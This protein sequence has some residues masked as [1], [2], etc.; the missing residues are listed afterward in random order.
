MNT[1]INLQLLTVNL[2]KYEPTFVVVTI[3]GL[4]FVLKSYT[5]YNIDFIYRKKGK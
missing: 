3:R 1:L 2:I 4:M 5:E